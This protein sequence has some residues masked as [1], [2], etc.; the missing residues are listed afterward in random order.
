MLGVVI[1]HGH[2]DGFDVGEWGGF[3]AAKLVSGAGGEEE[4]EWGEEE[5]FHGLGGAG[6]GR[7]GEVF[8][9]PSSL[10]R[11]RES[12]WSFPEPVLRTMSR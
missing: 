4:R 10:R 11:A 5:E 2:G 8:H 7:G 9:S 1:E 12:S 3:D 6:F